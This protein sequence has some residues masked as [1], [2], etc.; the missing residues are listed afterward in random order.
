MSAN[1][2]T[3]VIRAIM[4]VAVLAAG[5]GIMMAAPPAQ[6][7][8]ACIVPS[9]AYAT[10]QSAV[11][12]PGC[13]II[14]IS[15]GTYAENIVVNR[16]LTMNRAGAGALIIDGS[17]TGRVF[18]IS[19]GANVT[20]QDMTIQNGSALSGGS[21]GGMENQ[22]GTVTLSRV[23]VR[24]NTAQAAGGGIS[25]AGTM[26]ISQSSIISNTAS[27]S[28]HLGGGI[29]NQASGKLVVLNSTVSG[30]RASNNG[31]GIASLGGMVSLNNVTIANNTAKNDPGTSGHGGGAFTS[32]GTFTVLNSII[33]GNI[34][35]SATNQQPDCSGAFTSGG[36]NLIGNDAGCTGFVS[37][38]SGNRVGKS[39]DPLDARLG[40]LQDNGDGTLTH[41]LLSDSP[42]ANAA[43]PAA[44]G[45]SGACLPIDQRGIARPQASRCD[46]G[47]FESSWT[48]MIPFPLSFY[49]PLMQR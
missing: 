28:T 33:A 7:T 40:A 5:L 31:G 25:N 34:D 39:F 32:G 49:L 4:C 8:I 37:G 9:A 48:T 20:L 19:G 18:I 22:S 47:A 29:A 26:T 6:A 14:S 13:S 11:D 23:I 3:Q 1:H 35:P 27:G 46:M 43:S 10:I 12:D 2:R 44:P 15:A 36:Y 16:S 42:A 38:I 24:D 21:G 30:N 17:G 41:A 45:S